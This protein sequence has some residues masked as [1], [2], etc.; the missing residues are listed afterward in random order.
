M[1]H[2]IAAG[3]SSFDLVDPQI[4]LTEL[5][6]K[7]DTVLLDLACGVGNYALAAA[8]IIGAAGVIHA[9]DLWTEGI[10]SLRA[11]AEARGLTQIHARIADVNGPLPLAAA[12]VD[13]ALM[14]TV[15]HDLLA[16]GNGPATLAEVTRVLR[17]GGRLVI[18]EFDKVDGPPG[19]PASIRLTPTEV[20]T[21][22]DPF[23][24]RR[25]NLTQ[26]GDTLYAV[27]FRRG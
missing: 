14:A 5:R 4:V 2:P 1:A 7:S 21:F 6:L 22:I 17:P 13:V 25:E 10:A 11:S 16:E 9:L 19:P 15:L 27:S 24:Y 20:E 23:G 3:K 8:Q 26:V 18:I 12:S